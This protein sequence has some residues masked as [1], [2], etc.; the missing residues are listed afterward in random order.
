MAASSRH[1]RPDADSETTTR[2]LS[3]WLAM[4]ALEVSRTTDTRP[5]RRLLAHFGT[6]ADHGMRSVGRCSISGGL[7][8]GELEAAGP[9]AVVLVEKI[10]PVLLAGRLLATVDPAL[11]EDTLTTATCALV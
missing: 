2:F 7:A 5:V 11:R 4:E 1:W 8:H 10:A 6:T 3:C 9:A